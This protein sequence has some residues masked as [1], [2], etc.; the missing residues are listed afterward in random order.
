MDCMQ[1]LWLSTGLGNPSLW[2]LLLPSGAQKGLPKTA[3]SI[4]FTISSFK[5]KQGNASIVLPHQ[6]MKSW[7]VSRR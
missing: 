1:P 4:K 2:L 3:L 6:F 7:P 5:P